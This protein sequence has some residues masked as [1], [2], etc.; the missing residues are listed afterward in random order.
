MASRD[1]FIW[2]APPTCG[3]SNLRTP[4]ARLPPS[5]ASRWLSSLQKVGRAV[6]KKT[7]GEICAEAFQKYDDRKPPPPPLLAQ[8]GARR[9]RAV[10]RALNV[11]GLRQSHRRSRPN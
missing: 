4:G 6:P 10:P 1:R 5:P 9:R 8:D 2:D 3:T 11:V 7:D